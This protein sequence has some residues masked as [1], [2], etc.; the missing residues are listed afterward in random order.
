MLRASCSRYQPTALRLVG[1]HRLAGA[2]LVGLPQEVD[3]RGDLVVV[4]PA[5][6][7]LADP[8][9]YPQHRLPRRLGRVRGEHRPQLQPLQRGL[10]LGPRLAGELLG[11]AL[12]EIAQ[13]AVLRRAQGAQL[14]R[15]VQLLGGVGEL[16]VLGERAAERDRGARV[17]PGE[18]V[19]DLRSA[20]LGRLAR[21]PADLLDQ[22]QQLRPAVVGEGLA[23][24]G[25]QPA[26]VGAQR[27]VLGLG[28]DPGRVGDGVGVRRP[29]WCGAQQRRLAHGRTP[30]NSGVVGPL[31]AV[32]EAVRLNRA[33][34]RTADASAGRGMSRTGVAHRPARRKERSVT[35]AQPRCNGGR[36]RWTR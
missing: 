30:R 27:L 8:A 11:Q 13:R 25:R 12:H 10:H 1:D 26:D 15:A 33:S 2:D 21:Q 19:R 14:A 32:G 23:E 28:D 6:E 31:A 29:R 20:A 4:R 9:Q 35:S 16:E 24:H 17:Q 3:E 36:Q 7:R 18:Q 34:A 22:L 5:V